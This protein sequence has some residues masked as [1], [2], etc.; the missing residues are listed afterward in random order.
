MASDELITLRQRVQDLQGAVDTSQAREA[1]QD[2]TDRATIQ[3][4]TAQRDALQAIVDAG[5]PA[6][7]EELLE[8]VSSL[9]GVITDI[10]STG[11]AA[12]A[13]KKKAK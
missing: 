13:K 8:I 1:A 2:E 12:K 7:K 4:L 11:P 9:D 10:T 5:V 6:T 3:D